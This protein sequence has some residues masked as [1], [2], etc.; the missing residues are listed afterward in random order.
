[1]KRLT[2][3]LALVSLAVCANAK[4][5][6]VYYSFTNN[7]HR[8]V[9]D[10]QEQT[11]ADIVR[12]EPAQEGLDYAANNY[13]LGSALIS[14][15]RNNPD[16]AASYPEIKPVDVDFADYDAFIIAAPLWWSNMAAPLQTFLFHNGARLAGK[17]I[18]LIVSSASSGI[19]GVEADAHRLVPGG[20]FFT[21]SLWIRSSQTSACHSMISEWL[22]RIG[23]NS[24]AGVES[25]VSEGSGTRI[26][27]DGA[28]IV[29]DGDFDSLALYDMSGTRVLESSD[30]NISTSTLKPGIYIAS[31]NANTGSVSRK[32]VL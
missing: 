1:M 2:I 15:I 6:I 3:I 32:I 30:R 11:G 17:K 28:R 25:P 18:G 20:D 12:I 16:S 5:L 14:A 22:E 24:L 7:V 23:Y 27:V 19:S 29:V 9:S 26:T 31:I 10:L 8:I 13:A 21:P 4:T